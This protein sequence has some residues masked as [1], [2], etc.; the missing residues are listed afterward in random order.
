MPN[1]ISSESSNEFPDIDELYSISQ[2]G[3]TIRNNLG[4]EV[5]ASQIHCTT[6]R[7]LRGLNPKMSKAQIAPE[8]QK[9]FDRIEKTIEAGKEAANLKRQTKPLQPRKKKRL[10]SW[11]IF[12][13][14]KTVMMSRFRRDL[15]ERQI[16]ES[17]R[18]NLG[19]KGQMRESK[20]R[21][22]AENK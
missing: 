15:I 8:S 3:T 14:L 19:D 10:I 21:Q 22:A 1:I 12:R 7:A 9:R 13:S 18:K 11:M 6:T 20:R 16:E 2:G 4:V 5:S 17:G